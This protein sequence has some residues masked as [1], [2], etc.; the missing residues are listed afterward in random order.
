M[1]SIQ[2]RE[3]PLFTRTTGREA[4]RW[5]IPLIM[6]SE[7]PIG[8]I[9]LIAWSDTRSNDTLNR[10]KGVHFFVDDYRFESVYRWPERSLEKLA[11]YRFVLTPDYS[12]Y[13][14][15]PGWRQIESVG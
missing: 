14:D 10:K 8:N 2:M 3:N 4:G 5:G 1:T 15:M 7:F 6:K 11:Q 13:A 12:L 9:E